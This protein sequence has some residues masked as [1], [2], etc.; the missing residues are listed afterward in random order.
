MSITFKDYFSWNLDEVTIK[1]L[2]WNLPNKTILQFE[3]E[4]KNKMHQALTDS[5]ELIMINC[6]YEILNR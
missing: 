2:K 3:S 4:V 1:S 6:Q 5:S